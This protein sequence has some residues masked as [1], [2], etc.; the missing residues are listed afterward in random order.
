MWFLKSLHEYVSIKELGPKLIMI[1]KMSIELVGFM[2]IIL[3]FMFAFGI[4][5]QSLM[6]HNVDLDKNLLKK[7]FFPAYFVIAGEY[8]TWDT[9]NGSKS[10][11]FFLFI[12]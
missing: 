11:K 1:K 2:C 6:Y 8:F 3:V 7:I 9:I 10:N 5:T 4:T 12:I